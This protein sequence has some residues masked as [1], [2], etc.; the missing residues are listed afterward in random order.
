MEK[1]VGSFALFAPAGPV[2]LGA[3]QPLCVQLARAPGFTEPVTV[4]VGDG[5]R[6]T[7]QPGPG[8]QGEVLPAP[9]AQ[10]EC[11][12]RVTVRAG[13]RRD[14]AWLRYTGGS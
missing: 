7:A 4:E 14:A 11:A 5:Y 2:A 1:V 12:V 13:E 10:S 8:G 3:N 6:V 9:C